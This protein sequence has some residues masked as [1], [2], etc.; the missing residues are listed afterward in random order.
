MTDN[1]LPKDLYKPEE[2][3]ILWRYSEKV[4]IVAALEELESK[5]TKNSNYKFK[6]VFG[7]KGGIEFVDNLGKDSTLQ[8]LITELFN[9]E[10]ESYDTLD[11]VR[12]TKEKFPNVSI[13]MWDAIYFKNCNL[14]KTAVYTGSNN[15]VNSRL[16]ALK[17]IP[18]VYFLDLEANDNIF[19]DAIDK[20][21]NN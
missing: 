15:S 4:W 16:K 13:L 19:F 9:Y 7:P 17:A 21:L 11:L 8:I 10:H 2:V 5:A 20:L 6:H 1:N 3:S 14:S 18:D 12:K